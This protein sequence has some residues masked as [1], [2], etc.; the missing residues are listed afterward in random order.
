M[1]NRLYR[2][3]INSPRSRHIA[4][5]LSVISNIY[6]IFEAQFMRKLNNTE[7][8]FKKYIAYKKA[9]ISLLPLMTPY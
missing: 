9:C 7:T 4:Q 2:Y 8:E 1:K 5:E 3:N 6:T